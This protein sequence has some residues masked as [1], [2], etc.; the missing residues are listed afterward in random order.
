MKAIIT[1]AY[2]EPDVLKYEEIDEPRIKPNEI[3]V[4]VKYT[5][6]NPL[7]WKIRKGNMKII[8][9]RKAPKVLGTDYSGVVYAVGSSVRE[10][11]KGDKVFGLVKFSGRKDGTYAEFLRVTKEEIC[12]KPKSIS[13]EQAAALPMIAVTAYQALIVGTKLKSGQNVY[14]TGCTGGVGSIAVQIAKAF[15][16]TVTGVCSTN[17]TKLAKKLGVDEILDY[18]KDDLLN[19]KAKYDIIFDASG[20]MSYSQSKSLLKPK[21]TYI[22]TNVTMGAMM[23][24]SFLNNFRSQKANLVMAKPDQKNMDKI[25]DLIEAG[26]IKATIAKVFPLNKIVD[27]H[28]MSQKGGYSGKIVIKVQ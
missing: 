5:C 9:G 27:A 10:Y 1:T 28:E 14:I 20:T 19:E 24:G 22:T 13:F 16:C 3:L 18:K 6:I 26:K 12:K 2:G 23:F 8:S 15:H 11:R 21:G 7:D 4:A 17:N 25:K